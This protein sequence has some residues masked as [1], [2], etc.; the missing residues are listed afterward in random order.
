MFEQRRDAISLVLSLYVGEM[1]DYL[2]A[3][4]TMIRDLNEVLKEKYGDDKNS[5]LARYEIEKHI[6]ELYRLIGK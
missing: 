5:I 6:T 1:D 4:K 2:E 3:V